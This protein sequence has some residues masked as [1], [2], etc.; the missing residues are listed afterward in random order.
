MRILNKKWV[1]G[2]FLVMLLVF[3]GSLGKSISSQDD[4]NFDAYRAK[5]LSH[6][7]KKKFAKEHYSHKKNDD[8][9]SRVAFKVYLKQLDSQK[10]FLLQEDVD[11]LSE[12]EDRIDDEFN[13]GWVKLPLLASVVLERRKREVKVFVDDLLDEAY[14]FT[15]D[16]YLESDQDKLS[17]CRTA[18]ELRSRW[19]K[20]LKYQLMSRYLDL[21]DEAEPA[22][23]KEIDD[24]LAGKGPPE[25]LK[26]AGKKL[27]KNYDSY[28]ARKSDLKQEE[29]YNR[30][31]DAF[32]KAH[33]PHSS[34]LAPTR[35]EDF[36]IHMRGSLEG[37]GA[38]LIEKDGYI[39]VLS[40]MPGGAAY[41]QGEL[42]AE[43][44]IVAVAEGEEEFVEITDMS[45]REAVSL[46]R[47]KKGSRVRLDV[48]KSD[49][50][51][52][53]ISIIRD[54]VQIEE[55]F[56]KWTTLKRAGTDGLFGYIMIPSFYR[57]FKTNGNGEKTRN[58][59]DDVRA[60]LEELQAKN[61]GGLIL[62]LRNNGGGA[63]IDAITIAGLFIEKGPV[64]Q[65][66]DGEGKI[67]VR[68]DNDPEIV[69]SGPMVIL[70]NRLSASASEILA[71][72]MQD[73]R[74]AVIVGGGHTHGKGTVQS[75]ID[76]DRYMFYPNMLQYKP[77]GAVKVTVQ[78]FY[79]I[80]GGS[81]Q[82][83]GVVPDIIL[84]DR[85]GHVDYGEQYVENALPWDTVKPTRYT[86]VKSRTE[87]ISR[88]KILSGK[89]VQ[90]DSDF[91]DI[92]AEIDKAEERRKQ[93]KISL[94]IEEEKK[95]R[96]EEKSYREKFKSKYADSN[97]HTSKKNGKKVALTKEELYDL[98]IQD[99]L[100]DPYVKEA[101]SVLKD[102]IS[103]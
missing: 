10:R 43:D 12:Y 61:I 3:F 88:L 86:Q 33:D 93:T 74:R 22:E 59:T 37:I 100:I 41:R 26:L 102:M 66:K 27:K 57:D 95:N 44:V 69:Y 89:R 92:R 82:S 56:V 52:M 84:P 16:E 98:W 23:G 77:L 103:S 36:D 4:A 72:A 75:M 32:A 67:K 5:L 90:S 50:K 81:T 2:T 29:F 1:L 35:K 58:S 9:L 17:Y 79:R 30:Y 24:E 64:V 55:T 91:V 45:I 28:F 13:N 62:D 25:L 73:Y 94:N 15:K 34:Y 14:D 39:K 101:K 38:R 49:G 99:V 42:E 53:I 76:L 70:V 80:S 40:V 20:I 6:M 85:L 96:E 97:N 87:D 54:V 65:I 8:Q 51:R 48:K 18:K 46:I 19:R 47:G 63:L 11:I 78:K 7:I 71:G 21:L 60:A 31:F 83:R 68:S